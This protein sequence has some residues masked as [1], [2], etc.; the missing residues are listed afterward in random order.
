M[1]DPLAFGFLP[2]DLGKYLK[3]FKHPEEDKDSA[4][5]ATLAE[6]LGRDGF[7]S[8]RLLGAGADDEAWACIAAEG[9]ALLPYM[10]AGMSQGV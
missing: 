3:P 8:T 4:F 2:H 7:V 6:R 1:Y 5:F 9:E 10:R